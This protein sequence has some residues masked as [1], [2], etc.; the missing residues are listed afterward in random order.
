MESFREWLLNWMENRSPARRGVFLGIL[1]MIAVI[2]GGFMIYFSLPHETIDVTPHMLHQSKTEMNKEYY[3]TAV[4][5][6]KKQEV[7]LTNHEYERLRNGGKITIFR[8][9]RRGRWYFRTLGSYIRLILVGL[10]FAVPGILL[11]LIR[12]KRS[13]AY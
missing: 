1:T 5:D 11:N 9:R 13:S 8:Y 4:I 2:G 7:E 6:G 10:C 12:Q 3:I